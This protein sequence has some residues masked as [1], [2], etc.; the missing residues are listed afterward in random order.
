MK[1]HQ[2]IMMMMN[3]VHSLGFGGE[4][5]RNLTDI[6]EDSGALRACGTRSTQAPYKTGRVCDVLKHFPGYVGESRKN[7]TCTFGLR[8]VRGHI[9]CHL[10]GSANNMHTIRRAQ[11]AGGF[12]G[13]FP[14]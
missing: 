9:R 1:S 5:W 11:R 12:C 3:A 8:R 6:L 14:I 13:V 10:I 7:L 2:M 4:A